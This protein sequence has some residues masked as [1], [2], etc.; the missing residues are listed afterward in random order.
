[1]GLM[2]L[3]GYGIL[4]LE[5]A[6]LPLLVGIPL[7]FLFLVLQLA[8][9]SPMKTRMKALALRY[10]LAIDVMTLLLLFAYGSYFLMLFLVS[11]GKGLP[12]SAI[13]Y[14]SVS[15]TLSILSALILPSREKL[16]KN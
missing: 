7:N 5:P 1:L 14:L 8:R 2:A 3:D 4:D 12:P 10:A 11:R 6:Y 9:L 16:I 13:V 15:V